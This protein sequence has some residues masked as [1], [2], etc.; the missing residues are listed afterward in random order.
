MVMDPN[1]LVRC[2][3]CGNVFEHD[4]L[5][6]GTCRICGGAFD[7]PDVVGRLAAELAQR[8]WVR[9]EVAEEHG[10]HADDGPWGL[11]GVQLSGA[12]CA[13]CGG[14]GDLVAAYGPLVRLGTARPAA[15]AAD[16]ERHVTYALVAHSTCVGVLEAVEEAPRAETRIPSLYDDRSPGH[17][18]GEARIVH[19]ALVEA[20]RNAWDV[21]DHYGVGNLPEML[22]G[23]LEQVG[24]DLG[25]SHALVRHR[26]GSWEA[27]HVRGLAAGADYDW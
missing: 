19:E 7:D 26:P 9:V 8:A 23:A 11:T 4:R 15:P 25:G 14:A 2:A 22:R 10:W 27:N 21:V 6:D 1:G 18:R 16:D 3:S 17:A 5:P 12:A 13:E 20:I 24:R